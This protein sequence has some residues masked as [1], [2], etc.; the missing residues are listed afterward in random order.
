MN[1]RIKQYREQCEQ[2]EKQ[3]VLPET[4]ADQE[5]YQRLIREHAGL[6]PLVDL[7]AEVFPFLEFLHLS[8]FVV[9]VQLDL[10]IP[11]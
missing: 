8:R 7:D 5:T 4:I 9:L 6:K 2:I 1:D 10:C 11:L 3:L